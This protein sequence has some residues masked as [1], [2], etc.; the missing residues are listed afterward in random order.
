MISIKAESAL[1]RS[2]IREEVHS[3]VGIKVIA[4]WISRGL[5]G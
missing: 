5:I 4:F 2:H 1:L 3:L